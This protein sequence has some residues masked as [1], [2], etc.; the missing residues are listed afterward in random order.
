MQPI[1]VHTS[2]KFTTTNIQRLNLVT[3]F[4]TKWY[5]GIYWMYLIKFELCPNISQL[6][7]SKAQEQSQNYGNKTNSKFKVTQSRKYF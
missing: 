5:L 7:S 1:S 6:H 4:Y 2:H 3:C